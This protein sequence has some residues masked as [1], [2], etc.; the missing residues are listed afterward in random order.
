MKKLI[1]IIGIFGVIVCLHAD[2]QNGSNVILKQ[3]GLNQVRS[4]TLPKY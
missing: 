4:A 1:L 2:Q 3:N